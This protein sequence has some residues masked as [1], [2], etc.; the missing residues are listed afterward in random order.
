MFYRHI[1]NKKYRCNKTK[2]HSDIS[3]VTT[4]QFRNCEELLANMANVCIHTN[5]GLNYEEKDSYL[6]IF[7]ALSG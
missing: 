1:S 3:N 5:N 4:S 7:L 2:A 6:D